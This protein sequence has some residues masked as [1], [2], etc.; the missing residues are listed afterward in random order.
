MKNVPDL[1]N[2]TFKDIQEEVAKL[3]QQLANQSLIDPN[4]VYRITGDPNGKRRIFF[5]MLNRV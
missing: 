4:E 2:I 5:R 1:S 3:Q